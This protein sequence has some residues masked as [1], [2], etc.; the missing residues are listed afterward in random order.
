MGISRHGV[1]IHTL[2]QEI[3]TPLRARNDMETFGWSFCFAWRD[4]RAGRRGRCRPPYREARENEKIPGAKRLQGRIID[5]RY[6]PACPFGGATSDSTKSYPDNGGNRVPL[7]KS[8]VHR[9]DSGTRPLN[10]PHRLAPTAGSLE[11][12]NGEDFSVSVFKMYTS[13]I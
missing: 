8:L 13:D 9:T 3:A 10:P 7:L 1:R 5:P 12:W 11:H 6:H 2:F 4:I